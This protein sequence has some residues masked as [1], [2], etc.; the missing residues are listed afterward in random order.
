MDLRYGVFLDLGKELEVKSKVNGGSQFIIKLH[1]YSEDSC[2]RKGGISLVC[3]WSFEV[4]HW[5]LARY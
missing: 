4:A 1:W 5:T 3:G 2:L